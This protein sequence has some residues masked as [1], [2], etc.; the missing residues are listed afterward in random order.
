MPPKLH[1]LSATSLYAVLNVPCDAHQPMSSERFAA[2]LTARM[3]IPLMPADSSSVSP[4][5]DTSLSVKAP[6]HTMQ[7]LLCAAEMT[8]SSAPCGVHH[9]DPTRTYVDVYLNFAPFLISQMSDRC[10]LSKKHNVLSAHSLG[11]VSFRPH[12]P[13]SLKK[14]G[15]KKRLHMPI[16][17]YSMRL[18]ILHLS[19]E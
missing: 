10:R 19:T 5:P 18:H 4:A 15:G 7:A 9:H 3:T 13:C 14:M 16:S 12:S 2:A 1:Y 11:M 8:N 6:S 17:N